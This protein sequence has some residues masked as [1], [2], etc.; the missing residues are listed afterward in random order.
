MDKEDLIEPLAEYEHDRWARWQKHLFSKCIVNEDKSLTIP[1]EYVDRWARQMNTRYCNL[2]DDEKE[3]DRLE[4]IRML[5]VIERNT[6]NK[7]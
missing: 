1:K 3:S 2:D 6:N 5:N 7:E 4:A